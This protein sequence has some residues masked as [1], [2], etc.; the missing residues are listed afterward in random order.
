MSSFL[1]SATTRSL[2]DLCLVSKAA[3]FALAPLVRSFYHHINA[4]TAKLKADNSVFTIAD[5]LVQHM[6][7]NHLFQNK[8]RAVVG[9]EDE[10]NVNILTRP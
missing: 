1:S 8:F 10:T 7:V 5:G 9:E 3:C 6:L 4:D 2:A